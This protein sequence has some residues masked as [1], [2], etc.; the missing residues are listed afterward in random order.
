[1]TW[2]RM[3]LLG[4]GLF[5]V[6]GGLIGQDAKKDAKDAKDAKEM[7]EDK[8]TAKTKVKG[9]LPSGWAKIGLTDEQKQKV[10]S[11]DSDYDDK[12]EKLKA[13]IEEHKET[14]RKK[15]LEVLTPEQKKR[16]EANLKKAAGTDKDK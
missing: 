13:Q 14:K 7:K 15:Q 3:T 2:L 8:D 1:M 5:A 16:L 12:I 11:I 6:G 9:Q 4:L 10:Y